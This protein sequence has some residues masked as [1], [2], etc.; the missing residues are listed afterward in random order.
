MASKQPDGSGGEKFQ[1]FIPGTTQS[2]AVASSA[3]ATTNAFGPGVSVVRVAVSTDC[4][5]RFSEAGTAATSAYLFMPANSVEY[6]GVSPADGTI[7]LSAIRSTADGLLR[8]TEGA[9]S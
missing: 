3:A 7:K 4:Y 2:I 8:V 9:V 6:F 5:I 1:A